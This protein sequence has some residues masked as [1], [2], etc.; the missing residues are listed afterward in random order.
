MFRSSILSNFFKAN[1]KI[2]FI[3]QLRILFWL[4][5]K[6]KMMLLRQVYTLEYGVSKKLYWS[7]W[8]KLSTFF[9]ESNVS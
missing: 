6:V 8:M 5:F 7:G 3:N 1:F 4:S 9:L 2:K